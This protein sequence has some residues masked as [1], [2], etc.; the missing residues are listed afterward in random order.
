MLPT[1]PHLLVLY[2]IFRKATNGN[3]AGSRGLAYIPC[4]YRMLSVGVRP[5]SFL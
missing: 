3:G 1:E 4:Q 2:C 5:V